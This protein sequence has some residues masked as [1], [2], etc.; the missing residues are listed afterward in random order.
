MIIANTTTFNCFVQYLAIIVL[1]NSLFLV[2]S[3]SVLRDNYY[4]W[5]TRCTC[6]KK[7]S[8]C[9]KKIVNLQRNFLW[10][11][12]SE[13]RK[14]VWAS[15]EKVCESRESDELGVV[16]IKTFNSALLDKWIWWLGSNE[17]GM[18]KEILKS[19]Y[20]GWRKRQTTTTPFGGKI[21]RRFGRWRT[22]EGTSKTALSGKLVI[23]ILSNSGRTGG[24]ATLF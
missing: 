19:K 23:G 5:Q 15:W 9:V 24:W 14:I 2:G 13:G 4:F 20:G 6:R 1:G 18:W 10:G 8:S 7:S 22:G 12:G 21:W 16:N 11:W 3:I 17:G